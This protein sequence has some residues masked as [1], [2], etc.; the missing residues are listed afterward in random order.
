[1]QKNSILFVVLSAAVIFIWY[2]F[3]AP[4]STQVN[5]TPAQVQTEKSE[6]SSSMVVRN[7]QIQ[8]EISQ[9]ADEERINIETEKY[10]AVLTN[11]GAAVL[12]WSVKEKNGEWVDLVFPGS[13]PV[14]GNFPGSVYKIVSKSDSKIV[15][16]YV[17]KEGW[18]ITK[19]YNLSDSYMHNLNIVIDR[20]SSVS[21]PEIDIEWGPGLGTDA[22]EVKENVS[23]SRALAYTADKPYKLKKLK[24]D[25]ELASSYKWMAIDNR[26]F[27]AAFIPE[28]SSDFDKIIPSR[29]DKKHPYSVTMTATVPQNVDRK[30][31]SINFY[32]GPKG[33]T[34][35][36]SYNLGLEKTVDF[37]VFGFLGK[38]AFA[39]L[40][41]FYKI[42]HNYGWAIIMI[43]VV[44][45]ILVLPLTLKS[46]KSAAAMKRVQP[47]I[48]DIQTKYKNEPQRLQ[49]EMLNIYRTKKVNPLGGCLPML[50]QLPIF[51]AFFTMLRNAYELRNEGWILWVKDLSASDQFMYLG[52]F[53]INLLPLLM[54][55]GMFFQQRMTM[56][57]SDPMQKRM[58]YLMPIIFTFMFWS[59]PSGLVIYWITNS[60]ISMIE[61]Y[62]I[63]KEDEIKVKHS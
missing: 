23:L 39:V 43:T 6:Y 52:D 22:K 10:K 45:Q 63:I 47:L 19:I 18:K 13:S 31:Y 3:L 53:S 9:F 60:I 59:F 26:Y 34:Y 51:W 12:N 37:G 36:K 44:I 25:S 17:S 50:L 42:T 33:Y 54:G 16:E 5:Q 57:V 49:A 56:A 58:M 15:F 62:F 32:L 11:K 28:K 27:L 40:M 61:Q 41:F 30:E 55:V 21:V 35:L 2:F 24:T 20:N 46:L 48:K 7:N 1:M 14:M 29:L 38:I 4:Q 8:D